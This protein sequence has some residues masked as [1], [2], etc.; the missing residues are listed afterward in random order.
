VL[1]F[2][3]LFAIGGLLGS[4]IGSGTARALRQW[5]ALRRE[6]GTSDE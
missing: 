3:S 2:S 5:I 6:A 4:L 1:I